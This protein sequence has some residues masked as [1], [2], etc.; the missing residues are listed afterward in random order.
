[1]RLYD[2]DTH[3]A[4]LRT[5]EKVQWFRSPG[6]MLFAMVL[7]RKDGTTIPVKFNS[8]ITEYFG[9]SAVMSM[10]RDLPERNDK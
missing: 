7:K 10:V 1:M 9:M 5:P 3:T 2:T 6:H 8:R 4:L